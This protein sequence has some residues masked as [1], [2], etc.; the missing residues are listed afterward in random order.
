MMLFSSIF[1]CPYCDHITEI[2]FE[3]QFYKDEVFIEDHCSECKQYKLLN[4][5]DMGYRSDTQDPMYPPWQY[6]CVGIDPAK[7]YCA[8]CAEQQKVSVEDATPFCTGCENVMT[9]HSMGTGSERE[10]LLILLN[11]LYKNKPE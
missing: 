6:Q 2:Y 7:R 3:N 10:S 1:R 9:F 8:D 5:G 4:N 11:W